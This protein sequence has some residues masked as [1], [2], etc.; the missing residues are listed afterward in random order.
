MTVA[1]SERNIKKRVDRTR[2]RMRP[3]LI[4]TTV[5][6]VPWHTSVTPSTNA[7]KQAARYLCAPS[8]QCSTTSSNTQTAFHLQAHTIIARIDTQ[9]VGH[10]PY[11]NA[12]RIEHMRFTIT[13]GTTARWRAIQRSMI[14]A[15][16]ITT[17]FFC[18]YNMREKSHLSEAG[19]ALA[20]KGPNTGAVTLSKMSR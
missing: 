4:L 12:H 13:V 10:T 1:S 5:Q 11:Q 14:C 8:P 16:P 19:C 7:G 17:F 6:G 15:G 9:K 18:H 2:L 20:S 3:G